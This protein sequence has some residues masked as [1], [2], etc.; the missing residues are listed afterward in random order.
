MAGG[1]I[2]PSTQFAPPDGVNSPFT[3][4]GSG[5][6]FF[7][8]SQRPQQVMTGS[9]YNQNLQRG[10]TDE[11]MR[12]MRTG[13]GENYP[14]MYDYSPNQ[15]NDIVTQAGMESGRPLAGSAQFYQPVYQPQYRDYNMGGRMGV[16]QYGQGF[17]GF[18]PYMMQMQTPFNPYTNSFGFDGFGGFGGFGMQTPF[19]Q[20]QPMMPNYGPTQPIVSRSAGVRG[21]PNVM[22]RRAEGGIA[23]LVS[24]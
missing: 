4:P 18:N 21:T 3:T 10:M 24:E 5:G 15:W 19:S 20:P 13:P 6:V 16:S 8:A 7:G 14:L 12:T 1:G 11:Q 22:M 23:D 9:T 17:G 2:T